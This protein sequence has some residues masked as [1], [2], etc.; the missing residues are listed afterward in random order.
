MFFRPKYSII[1]PTRDEEESIGKVLCSIPN[2]IRKKSEIIVVD[3]ST[4]YTPIIAKKLGARVIIEKRKGK[5]NAIRTGVN[6]SRGNILIFLDGDGTDPP[7]YIPKL[8]LKLKKSNLVLGCRSSKS[9]K[10]DDLTMRRIFKLY[11]ISIRPIFRI[12]GLKVGDPLAGFR[13]I[14]RSDWDKLNLKSKGFE[15]ETEMNLKALDKEFDIRQVSIPHFKRGG[16]LM[17]SKLISNPR[18]WFKIINFV[19]RYVEKKKISNRI[20]K[21]RQALKSNLRNNSII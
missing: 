12:V 6:A 8:L 9:F 3:S 10:N 17:K 18:S 4:D 14:R 21:I 1:I 13:A 16:G 19:L 15:I 5:G 7:Q 2:E 11:G 20:K